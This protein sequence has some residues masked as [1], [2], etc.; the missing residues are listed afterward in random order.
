ML[1]LF[2]FLYIIQLLCIYNIYQW[3]A[4]TGDFFAKLCQ[5][6]ETKQPNDE[7]EKKDGGGGFGGLSRS[8]MDFN[9]HPRGEYVYH[10]SLLIFDVL[11]Y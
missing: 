1:L 9:V 11:Q 7:D 10:I 6:C 5:E 8:N 4:A 2:T 3:Q